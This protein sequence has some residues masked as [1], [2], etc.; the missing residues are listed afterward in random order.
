MD[1]HF[2]DGEQWFTTRKDAESTPFTVIFSKAPLKAPTFLSSEAG[3]DLTAEE[4][5]EL[6]ELKK[7]YAASAPQLV[8]MKDKDGNQPFV[9]VLLPERAANEPIIFDVS[10]KRQ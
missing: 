1:F 5:Q 4:R 7:R 3:R 2:P 8:A 10:I 9:S 6:T